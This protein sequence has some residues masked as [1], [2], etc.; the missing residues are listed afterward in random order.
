MDFKHW[1][2]LALPLP[3]LL[4]SSS[5]LLSYTVV[6]SGV[7]SGHWLVLSAFLCCE[8]WGQEIEV[9]VTF[10]LPDQVE[11]AMRDRVRKW[12]LKLD[13]K[14]PEQFHTLTKNTLCFPFVPIWPG[15]CCSNRARAARKLCFVC[16]REMFWLVPIYF[17]GLSADRSISAGSYVIWID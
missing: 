15:A 1:S 4:N 9:I 13:E 11:L 8:V 16:V 6:N 7:C 2:H 12:D 14:W 10:T 3:L 17:H 5:I